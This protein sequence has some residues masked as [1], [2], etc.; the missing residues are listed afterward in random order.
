MHRVGNDRESEDRRL[1][2]KRVE[3]SLRQQR[4]R[5]RNRREGD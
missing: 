3:T 1:V 2:V 5:E 4:G